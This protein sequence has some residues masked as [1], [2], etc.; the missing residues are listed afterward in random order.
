MAKKQQQLN[1]N[2][3]DVDAVAHILT[4]ASGE[5]ISVDMI[6]EDI[7]AGAPVNGDGTLNLVFYAAWLLSSGN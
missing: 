4:Q 6:N 3:M 2:A 1:P 5:T 7:E